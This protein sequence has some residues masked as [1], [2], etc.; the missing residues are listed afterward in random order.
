MA[1]ILIVD[2]Q[3]IHRLILRTLLR[4]N[5]YQVKEAINGKE[6]LEKA[7]IAPPDLI[8]SDLLM[9]VMDGYT[10]LW[11]WKKDEKLRSVGF[12]VYSATYLRQKDQ[13][14]A[15][16]LGADAFIIKPAKSESLI[17]QIKKILASNKRREITHSDNK[18]LFM[19]YH[20]VLVKKLEDKMIQLRQ[21]NQKLE[22]D[23]TARKQTEEKY[24]LLVERL[25]LATSSAGIGV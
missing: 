25:S 19:T 6:A 20:E 12:I 13:Q 8:I 14:L 10:L 11:H 22:K 21:V 7:R 3:E 15:R 18:M 23:I 24:Q 9:P 1:Y 16:D 5:G 4:D 2:D 17:S